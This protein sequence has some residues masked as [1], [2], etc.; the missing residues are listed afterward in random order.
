MTTEVALRQQFLT[1]PYGLLNT[2][3]LL[4]MHATLG[5]ALWFAPPAAAAH[6]RC[7]AS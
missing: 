4:A 6:R 2:F 1:W 7:S 5:V 3:W